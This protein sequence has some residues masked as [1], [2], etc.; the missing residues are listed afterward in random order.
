MSYYYAAGRHVDAEEES[1][2]SVMAFLRGEVEQRDESTYPPI[3]PWNTGDPFQINWEN[4]FSTRLM[5][6]EDSYP[7][8]EWRLDP[9]ILPGI[10]KKEYEASLCDTPEDEK[11][12]ACLTHPSFNVPIT[13]EEIATWSYD[14]ITEFAS[15]WL[16]ITKI[17]CKDPNNPDRRRIG[18]IRMNECD[19]WMVGMQYDDRVIFVY[20]DGHTGIHT[21]QCY[22][23]KSDGSYGSQL[24]L[25]AVND[26]Q[27]MLVVLQE[28]I[29]KQLDMFR[30]D[31]REAN[32]E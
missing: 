30:E 6:D 25:S 27:S 19:G 29:E 22:M 11:E 16:T 15:K 1:E 20:D 3:I 23:T 28:I 7:S 12:E 24:D 31:A 2:E 10:Q 32:E 26:A 8:M 14:L 17:D 5:M 9:F 4:F 13:S 21:E 18:I